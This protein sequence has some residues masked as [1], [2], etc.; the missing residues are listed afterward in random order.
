[1]DILPAADTLVDLFAGGCAITHAALE[2]GKYRRVIANDLDP[3]GI[4]LFIG[5]I[6]GKYREEK[7]WISREDF[8]AL[9]DT[10]PYVALC[11]SFG[12]NGRDYICNKDV[13]PYKKAVHTML[14]AETVHD[15]RLAYK[16]VI[17]EIRN[18]TGLNKQLFL[19]ERNLENLERV[20]SLEVLESL[21]A[22]ERIEALRLPYE[23]VG[24]PN[25]SVVYCDIP[26]KDTNE[27][28]VPFD[29][30]RFLDWAAE[31]EQPCFVS[32]YEIED[33]RFECV[34]EFPKRQ[35]LSST[36]KSTVK[37]ERLY[38]PTNQIGGGA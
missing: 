22:L 21:E 17:T 37:L 9:K 4:D 16:A 33:A 2:S 13:E 1:M 14:M 15:R 32:S 29:Y 10:D 18:L 23:D 3:R 25:G 8:E 36:N 30:D 7:R 24:I 6:Q 35:L 11:W 31:C 28:N 34:A 26:Y 38:R 5:A 12:T 27:Y 19:Q 20:Q